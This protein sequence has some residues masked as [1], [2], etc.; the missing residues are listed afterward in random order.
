[1]ARKPERNQSK[2]SSELKK[3][4]YYDNMDQKNSTSFYKNKSN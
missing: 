2:V 3:R 4:V 1:M